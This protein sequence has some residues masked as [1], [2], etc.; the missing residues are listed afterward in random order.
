MNRIDIQELHEQPWLPG[1]LRDYMT[2]SLQFVMGVVGVYRPILGRLSD[3]VDAAGAGRLVDL[4]SGA[5]G[6]W[7]WLYKRVKGERSSDFRIVL[8]DKYPNLAAFTRART[9]SDG[10][11]D[12]WPEPVDAS[13]LPENLGGF[14]TM[15]TSFHHFRPEEASSIL[16]G[17]VEQR[18]GIGVFELP[19]RSLRTMLTVFLVPLGSL[20]TTPFMRPFRW[21]RLLWT[22]ILPV[23]PFMLWFDGVLSCLRAYTPAEMKQLSA[24]LGAQDYVWEAGETGRPVAVTYLLGYPMPAAPAGSRAPVRAP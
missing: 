9:C 16:R 2:D 24:E 12:F 15:F 21:T 4:C 7:P 18:Q 20:L 5:G 23:V 6:P 19:R 11:I 17:A 13:C 8:T 10:V 14:R 3:A 1:F 22:Y